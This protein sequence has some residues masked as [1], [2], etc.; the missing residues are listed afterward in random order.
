MILAGLRRILREQQLKDDR[1]PTISEWAS[2]NQAIEATG[3]KDEPGWSDASATEWQNALKDA[4]HI[5]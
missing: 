3:F 4:L 5:G 2:I 1:G